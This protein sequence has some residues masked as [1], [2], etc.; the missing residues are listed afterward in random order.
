M[1]RS[2]SVRACVSLACSLGLAA[3]LVACA[4]P[5]C[6]CA[7]E[8]VGTSA[9]ASVVSST[10]VALTPPAASGWASASASGST[11]TTTPTTV[12]AARP[13]PRTAGA[14]TPAPDRVEARHILVS[15]KGSRGPNQTRTKDEARRI[16]DAI[17]LRLANGESFAA[18]AE[19]LGEDGTR[20]RGGDLGTF[21]RGQMVKSF[22]D[23]VFA[24]GVG[25]VATVETE[26]GFHVVQRTK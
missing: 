3:L 15:F 20:T 17:V 1:Q 18:L 25:E 2:K 24:L 4:R 10:G 9:A 6:R 5:P 8:G 12:A 11:T 23:A 22:E 16:L 7:N 21:G 13:A 14:A 26:F 19:E